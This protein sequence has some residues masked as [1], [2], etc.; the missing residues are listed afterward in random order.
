MTIERAATLTDTVRLRDQV[1]EQ[2]RDQIITGRLR[3]GHRLVERELAELFGVSRVPVR[4][5]IGLLTKEGFV[6]ALSPRRIVVKHLSR[7]DVE[8]LFDVRE[9]L[10][11]L[12]T[13]QATSRAD[14]AGLRELARLL[15]KA[16]LA[17]LT[18][19]LNTLSRAN[20]AFHHHV[21]ELA[22]NRLLATLLEPLEGRLR[23]VFQQIDDPIFVWEEHR[24]LCEAI[25]SGDVEAAGAC[26][27]RHVQRNRATALRVLYGEETR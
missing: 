25:S 10:E 23:W 27:L 5:A 9:S 24:E 17:T 4:E 16:R 8:E 3:P 20:A 1:C 11:A 26:S 13:R 22:D 12:A 2:I 7:R 6:D 19:E 15:E 14:Q 18:G 21:I